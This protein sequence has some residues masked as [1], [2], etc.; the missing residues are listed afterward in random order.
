HSRVVRDPAPPEEKRLAPALEVDAPTRQVIVD[1]E[2]RLPTVDAEA[3]GEPERHPPA[4]AHGSGRLDLREH[5]RTRAID[6]HLIASG[7]VIDG[8]VDDAGLLEPERAEEN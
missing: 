1:L 7:G 2:S 4:V 6:P 5:I 3:V 8:L